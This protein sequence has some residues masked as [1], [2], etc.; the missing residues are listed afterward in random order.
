LKASH[1]ETWVPVVTGRGKSQVKLLAGQFLFGC[2]SASSELKV[3]WQTIYKRMLKL[4]S[5]GNL[6]IQTQN[7]YSIVTICNWNTYQQGDCDWENHKGK[8]KE[9]PSK[10]QAKP[11]ENPRRTN[12][13]GNNGKNVKNEKNDKKRRGEVGGS[14]FSPLAFAD[15]WNSKG[16]LPQARHFNDQRLDKLSVR[17]KEP[18]FADNWQTIVDKLCQSSFCTGNN[19][20]GWKADIDWILKNSTNYAKVL[21]DKYRDRISKDK[22]SDG[23][24]SDQDI[25]KVLDTVTRPATLEEGRRL[26]ELVKCQ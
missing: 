18:L 13:N 14:N 24:L 26:M 12:N 5:L 9:N 10:N 1:K 16:N 8:G 21:E 25:E 20:R 6:K 4:E 3:P 11:K 15:Y 19:D 23:Q 7:H 2:K 17:M 22:E